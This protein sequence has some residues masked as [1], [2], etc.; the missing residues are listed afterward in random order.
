MRLSRVLAYYLLMHF[1]VW[2][3]AVALITA[4]AVVIVRAS[5]SHHPEDR[6]GRRETDWYGRRK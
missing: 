3:S 5:A 1:M 2:A 4:V 6:A